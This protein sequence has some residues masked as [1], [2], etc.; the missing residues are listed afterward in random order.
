[1][2]G[3]SMNNKTSHLFV[4]LLAVLTLIIGAML[5]QPVDAQNIYTLTIKVTNFAGAATDLLNIILYEEILD[6]NPKQVDIISQLDGTDTYEYE[7]TF[8]FFIRRPFNGNCQ[9]RTIL[10]HYRSRNLRSQ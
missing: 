1:M 6:G 9:I 5:P 10:L 4:S 3:D 2:K 8:E 7:L